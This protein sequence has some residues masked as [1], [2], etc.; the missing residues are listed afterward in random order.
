MEGWH[1]RGGRVSLNRIGEEF[2]RITSG[3]RAV[4]ISILLDG[5]TGGSSSSATGGGRDRTSSGKKE[6]GPRLLLLLGWKLS[7]RP[8]LLFPFFCFCFETCK[9]LI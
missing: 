3:T 2:G 4:F 7:P 6:N 8:F 1:G 5:M 9:T